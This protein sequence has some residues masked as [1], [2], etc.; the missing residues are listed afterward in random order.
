MGRYLVVG[1]GGRTGR[2]VVS[3]LAGGG[4]QA[5]VASRTP[6]AGGVALDLSAVDA[7]SA[8]FGGYDGIVVTVE[9]PVD[10]AGADRLLHHGVAAAAGAAAKLGVPFVVVSQIYVTRPEAYPAMAEVIVARRRGEEAVR[11][12]GAAYVIVRPGWLHDG[13]ARGARVEQGDTGDGQTSRDSVADACVAG[14]LYP[15]R[16]ALTFELFDGATPIDWPATLRALEPDL[17]SDD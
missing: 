2:R 11:E 14:L 5:T 7:G 4:H 10:A 13:P 6:R 1:G 12:S 3:R 8:V 15:G 17:A 9:P 16:A